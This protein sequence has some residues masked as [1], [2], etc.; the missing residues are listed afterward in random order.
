MLVLVKNLTGDSMNII[1]DVQ[2]S[3]P[4][5]CHGNWYLVKSMEI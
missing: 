3:L 1:L 5:E 4:H 2:N